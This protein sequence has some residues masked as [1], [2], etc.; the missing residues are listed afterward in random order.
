LKNNEGQEDWIMKYKFLE[1]TADVKFQSFGKNAEEAFENSALALKETICRKIK[2]KENEERKIKI[3]GKDF[4]SM[5]YKFLEEILY[6]LEAE[7]FLISRI[8]KIKI[9]GFGLNAV[10]SGDRASSYKFTNNAKAIT[11]NEMYVKHEKNKWK[12]QAVIDV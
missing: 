2:V 12:I 10:I 5:L 11:Y 4:E 7:N 9:E 1:H 6:L 8:K 3:K